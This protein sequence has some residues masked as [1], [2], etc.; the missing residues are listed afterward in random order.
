MAAALTQVTQQKM[1]TK[2]HSNLQLTL[3][4]VILEDTKL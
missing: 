4:Q 3:E 2:D 1:W